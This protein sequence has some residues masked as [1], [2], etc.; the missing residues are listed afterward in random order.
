MPPSLQSAFGLVAFLVPAWVIRERRAP[1]PSRTVASG[2]ALQRVVAAAMLR[3]GA[4][5]RSFAAQ[6]RL[7]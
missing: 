7:Q 3:M 1:V 2:V 5:H 6:D 4:A